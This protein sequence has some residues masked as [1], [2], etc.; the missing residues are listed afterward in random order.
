MEVNVTK[1]DG[2]LAPYAPEKLRSSLER[3]GAT[4]EEADA[5][6]RAVETGLH[7]KMSTQVIYKQAFSKLHK[8]A[9]GPAAR[10]RLKR[11]LFD[12][13]PTGFPFERFIGRVFEAEGFQVRTGV[14]AEGRCV[15]HEI[16]VWAERG[17]EIHLAECKFH[18]HAGQ[19][20]S[21]QVPLYFRSRLVDVA[22]RRTAQ[23]LPGIPTGWVVTNTRLSS[24]ALQYA[25]CIGLRALDWDSPDG[26]GLRELIDRHHL[27][28]VTCLSTL[29]RMEKD[30]LIGGGTVLCSE[31]TESVLLQRR[32]D[33]RKIPGVL[34]ECKDLARNGL[35]H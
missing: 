33:P 5:V 17:E 10:Y 14:Q 25:A 4:P 9:K 2:T 15:P 3:A 1:A 19:K 27:H 24:E 32:I 23:G 22:E 13:G 11:A 30:R 8:Q 34:S 12:L 20:S 29:N 28:P 21:I 6:A 18:H 7:D 16:D 26:K 35:R 31:V